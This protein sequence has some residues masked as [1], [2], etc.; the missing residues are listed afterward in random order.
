VAKQITKE[1]NTSNTVG[2]NQNPV[3]YLHNILQQPPPLYEFKH[4]SPKE[5]EKFDCA[6]GGVATHSTLK[7]VPTLPR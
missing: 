7:P 4:V 3:T 2:S 5:I 1:I 6:V